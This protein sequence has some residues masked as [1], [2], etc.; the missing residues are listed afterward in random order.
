MF[1][2]S[3]KKLTLIASVVS[4][5]AM[6]SALAEPNY[7]EGRITFTGNVLNTTCIVKVDGVNGLN[8]VV[9]LGEVN[10]NLSGHNGHQFDIA[11]VDCE[12]DKEISVGFLG[13]NGNNV[14]EN[15][16]TAQ[17]IG[18]ELINKTTQTDTVIGNQTITLP[19]T[20]ENGVAALRLLAK[21]K[22]TGDQQITAGSVSASTTV[23]VT[24]K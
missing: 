7:Q 1:F 18:V 16:G 19:K 3:E 13:F 21:Y 23:R 15:T 4:A 6:Q 20:G 24:Y 9:N 17:S 22:K 5:F 8:K 12:A 11:F 10:K 14:L 2:I